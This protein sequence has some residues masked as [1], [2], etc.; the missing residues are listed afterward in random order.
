MLL[1][2]IPLKEDTRF[3]FSLLAGSSTVPGTWQVGSTGLV[4]QGIKMFQGRVS[5]SRCPDGPLC[6]F[7]GDPISLTWESY[8]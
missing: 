6:T 3:T 2:L 8:G 5:G 4:N 7:T 1:P